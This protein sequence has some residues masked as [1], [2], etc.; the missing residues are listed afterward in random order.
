MTDADTDTTTQSHDWGEDLPPS[1]DTH[2]FI[3]GGV[4]QVDV[5]RPDSR[6]GGPGGMT[7][8]QAVALGSDLIRSAIY[9]AD[10]DDLTKIH[11]LVRGLSD[12]ADDWAV[13]MHR[14]PR[15][16]DGPYPEHPYPESPSNGAPSATDSADQA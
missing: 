13:A 3:H 1:W 15:C 12:F 7:V 10:I 9:V 5:E 11:L 4:A 14:C 16:G 6:D 2:G 8:S